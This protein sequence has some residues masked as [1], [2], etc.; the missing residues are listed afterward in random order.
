MLK[1]KRLGL[2][3]L[4]VAALIMASCATKVEDLPDF[5]E[6]NQEL[7][8]KITE[9]RNKAIEAGAEDSVPVLFK[10]VELEYEA[11]KSAL[12]N[13]ALDNTVPFTELCTRYQG[14]T[15]IAGAESKKKLIDEKGYA[16]YD[17]NAYDAGAAIL[18][19]FANPVYVI[20]SGEE[21]LEKGNSAESYMAK[22][23]ETAEKAIL[24]AKNKAAFQELTKQRENA[25]NA[26][27]DKISQVLFNAAETEYKT[28]ETSIKDST[29]D[30][31]E[32]IKALS[33]RYKALEELA[34]AKSMKD[35]IDSEGFA[36]YSQDAYNSGSSI[37]KEVAD[38]LYVVASGEDLLEQ[39]KQAQAFFQKV[40]DDAAEATKNEAAGNNEKNRL[41]FQEVL[42]NRQAA[43]DAGA[44]NAVPMLY[45]VVDAQYKAAELTLENG[46]DQTKE[47]KNLAVNFLILETYA[48]AMQKKA[49]IEENEYQKYD[50]NAYNTGCNAL[51][52]FD[53][54][55][56][57]IKTGNELLTKAR[58]ADSQFAKNIDVGPPA[59]QK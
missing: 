32:A 36:K 4:A 31:T 46:V 21:I 5:S 15:S 52:E 57:A 58:T 39:A 10:S 53:Q 48:Q 11:A 28:L 14:L 42:K 49:L 38:P 55:L 45:A 34:K 37:L 23:I 30:E 26:G 17:Q 19:D 25:I 27:A 29:V 43:I 24:E 41:A 1:L 12:E 51:K 59:Q 33:V 54:P 2:A 50:M 56:S 13:P 44:E 35:K 18:Q 40:M 3:F 8:N 6:Q 22:V 9:E 16:K 47:I 7:F 20:S